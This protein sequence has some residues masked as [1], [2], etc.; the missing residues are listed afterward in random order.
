MIFVGLIKFNCAKNYLTTVISITIFI[1]LYCVVRNIYVFKKSLKSNLYVD[2]LLRNFLTIGC[3]NVGLMNK[4][5]FNYIHIIH[6]YI[7]FFDVNEMGTYMYHKF[8]F[9]IQLV[10]SQ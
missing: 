8:T 1:L 9:F 4:H 2:Y 7:M 5:F 10:Y 3:W 6:T